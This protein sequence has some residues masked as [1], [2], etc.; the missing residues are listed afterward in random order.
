MSQAGY[1][2]TAAAGTLNFSNESTKANRTPPAKAI[3]AALIEASSYVNC[4][5]APKGDCMAAYAAKDQQRRQNTL[6]TLK[7][8]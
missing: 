6:D 3:R 7:L 5:L 4:L 1:A 2:A 8:E